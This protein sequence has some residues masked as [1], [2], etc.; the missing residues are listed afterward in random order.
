MQATHEIIRILQSDSIQ[1]KF[2]DGNG[3]NSVQITDFLIL[4]H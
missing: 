2:I 4:K 1:L 3:T